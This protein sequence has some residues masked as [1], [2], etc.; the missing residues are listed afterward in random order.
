MFNPGPCVYMEKI[1]VGPD[2]VGS[3]DITASPTQNLR[4][5]AKAKR[6]SVR[7]L[8]VVILDRERHG[9]LIDEVRSTGA[10]I[11]LI[12]DGDIYGA[13]ATASPGAGADLLFGI[14]GTPEG[15]VAAAALKCMGGELQG[16]LWPRNDS[17]RD[18]GR[19]PPATT[20]PPSCPPTTSSKAT[21][22]SSPPPAS[23]TASCC[24]ACA[25][26]RGEPAPSRW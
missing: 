26:S 15:V 10:R 23:P 14:G 19:S 24:R 7:D 17:E 18:L 6:E 1:A 4:W 22:A 5:V 20:C 12:T 8:T 13:I 11:R 2:A 25:S 9:D 3:I 21:T 16:R